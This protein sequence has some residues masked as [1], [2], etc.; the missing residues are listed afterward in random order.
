MNIPFSLP[1]NVQQNNLTIF[2]HLQFLAINL[3]V[4]LLLLILFANIFGAIKKK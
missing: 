2:E 4:L 1:L 3:F